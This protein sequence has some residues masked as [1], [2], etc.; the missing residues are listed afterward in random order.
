MSWRVDHLQAEG[1]RRR[2]LDAVAPLKVSTG[3]A[4]AVLYW[5]TPQSEAESPTGKGL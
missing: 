3:P 2:V 4:A 1:L 5:A